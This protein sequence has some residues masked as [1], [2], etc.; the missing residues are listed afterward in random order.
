LHGYAHRDVI[1]QAKGILMEREKCSEEEAFEILR[2]VSSRLH[3]KLREVA[4]DVIES[5]GEH[6]QAAEDSDTP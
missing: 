5:S 6:K 2:D 3:R 4:S 1:G